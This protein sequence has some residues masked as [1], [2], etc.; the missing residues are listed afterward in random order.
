MQIPAVCADFELEN[1]DVMADCV[2]NDFE[3]VVAKAL[4]RFWDND[5]EEIGYAGTY[6][7]QIHGRLRGDKRY[8]GFI[9]TN[10][11]LTV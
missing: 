8:L 4:Q 2:V 7:I 10:R 1:E 5:Y 9:L 11:N 6:G 3:A